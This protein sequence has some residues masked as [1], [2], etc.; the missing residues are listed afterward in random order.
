MNSIRSALYARVS[1][2]QQAT[3]HTIDGQI[4]ALSERAYAG[5]CPARQF[6]KMDMAG[7]ILIRPAMDRRRDW[8]PLAV[9]I[10]F[11]CT[12]RQTGA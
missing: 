7:A 6:L 11:T 9:W 8:L 1:S 5:G 3:A 4:S 10:A 12:H 2:E